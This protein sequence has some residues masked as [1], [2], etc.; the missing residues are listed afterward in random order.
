MVVDELEPRQTFHHKILD[1]RLIRG[2]DS[3]C[4]DRRQV[5]NQ[6]LVADSELLVSK[7][8]V[9]DVAEELLK[10]SGMGVLLH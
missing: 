9:P 4:V 1:T 5:G 8:E 7:F 3:V 2:V 6:L 10:R